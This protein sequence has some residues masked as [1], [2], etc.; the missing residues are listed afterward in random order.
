MISIQIHPTNNPLFGKSKWW[1][2]PDMPEELDWPGV[3][4]PD[5]NG[6]V[7]EEPLT[8]ICQ[9]CCDDIAALDPENYL[10]HEGML[11]FFAAI[12]YFLGDMDALI[13]PGTGPW[14]PEYYRV[15]YTPKCDDL[16]THHLQYPDGTSA[17]LPAEAIT[18]A[19]SNEADDGNRLLGYPYIEDVREAM[20]N[21]LSLLQIEENDRWHL[22]FHDCGILYFLM[23]PQQLL[24]RQWEK[25]ECY[26]FSL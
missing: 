8:F 5:D 24:A 1:G 20:P 6:K 22:T 18:F 2:E 7:Y 12:D 11:Y 17:T 25:I 19:Q 21:R 3:M 14:K 13:Y 4:L 23:D 26:L 10:P 15:L 9:I 16:H